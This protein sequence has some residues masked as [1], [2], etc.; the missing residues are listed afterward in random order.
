MLGRAKLK[1]RIGCKHSML[2]LQTCL[3]VIQGSAVEAEGDQLVYEHHD[4]R[5]ITCP[6]LGQ[7]TIHIACR[8]ANDVSPVKFY[9]VTCC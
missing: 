5:G 4:D 2:D 7:H 8:Q 6:G 9:P 1:S 3:H